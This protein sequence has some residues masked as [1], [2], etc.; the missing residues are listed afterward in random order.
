MSVYAAYWGP[1][2]MPVQLVASHTPDRCWVE[3]GWKSGAVKHDAGLGAGGTMPRPGEWRTF[4]A[5]DRELLNVQ[6]WH[7][8]SSKTY[9][10]GDR[11]IDYFGL[12]M[13]ARRGRAGFPITA[14]AVFHPADEQ[15]AF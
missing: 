8:V 13:V 2:K 12:A 4:L 3:N 15:P 9:D 5:P 10:Y 7:L 1:G 6:F 11:L 14:A